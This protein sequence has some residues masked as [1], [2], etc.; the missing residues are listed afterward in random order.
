MI[1]RI[2]MVDFNQDAPEEAFRTYKETQQKLAK[3]RCV[4]RMRRGENFLPAQEANLNEGM[5]RVTFPRIVSTWDFEDET[6][7][8][9]FLNAP[10][11]IRMSKSDWMDHISWRYVANLKT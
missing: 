9:E 10:E 5:P 4:K 3:L 8:D 6:G 2:V 7:L 1:T 11:H